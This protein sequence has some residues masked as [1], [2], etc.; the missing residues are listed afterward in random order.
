MQCATIPLGWDCCQWLLS[1]PAWSTRGLSSRIGTQLGRSWRSDRD[2]L[3]DYKRWIVP[4]ARKARRLQPLRTTQ[5]SFKIEEQDLGISVVSFIWNNLI[6]WRSYARSHAHNLVE[7]CAI[8]MM[9][10][11]SCKNVT[12]KINP[13]GTRTRWCVVWYTREMT[14]SLSLSVMSFLDHIDSIQWQ[15][16]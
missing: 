10:A 8:V 11:H 15:E 6:M 9:R 14:P 12:S 3:N 7:H 16:R 1:C 13:A 5:P 2:P 4:P